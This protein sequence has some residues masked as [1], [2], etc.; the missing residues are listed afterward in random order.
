MGNMPILILCMPDASIA[1]APRIRFNGIIDN[2]VE[3][4]ISALYRT[5]G[6]E[7]KRGEETFEV[8]YNYR[9][10]Y[11]QIPLLLAYVKQQNINPDALAL[12]HQPVVREVF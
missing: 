11:K 4:E 7:L 3:G 8:F 10:Y 1:F 9:Y 12:W 6:F 5:D 2:E